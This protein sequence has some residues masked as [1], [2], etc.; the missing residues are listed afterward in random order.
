MALPCYVRHPCK[1][2]TVITLR[3][4]YMLLCFAG[5]WGRTSRANQKNDAQFEPKV[6]PRIVSASLAHERVRYEQS[7]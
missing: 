7:D 3:A 5:T 1:P 6:A 4:N 2:V